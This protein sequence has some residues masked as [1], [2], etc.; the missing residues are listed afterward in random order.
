MW[1][2]DYLF[3]YLTVN[4]TVL[5]LRISFSSAAMIVIDHFPIVI[6][7]PTNKYSE[8]LVLPAFTNVFIWFSTL[9]LHY[10]TGT[11]APKVTTPTTAI[12]TTCEM[13]EGMN[14]RQLIPS[15]DIQVWKIS[16]VYDQND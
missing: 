11:T 13:K 10:F 9:Y 14:D 15:E 1:S 6:Q 7:S 16:L 2:A 3:G 8:W 4:V 5:L 12:T